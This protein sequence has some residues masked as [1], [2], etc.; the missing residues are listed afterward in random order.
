MIKAVFAITR[1]LTKS[2]GHEHYKNSL[3]TETE[4]VILVK[5][6]RIQWNTFTFNTEL[7]FK[8][9]GRSLA[10]RLQFQRNATQRIVSYRI[11]FSNES[12]SLVS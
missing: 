12:L 1:G 5:P 4:V 6:H 2:H 11:D 10:T 8:W 3:C 9:N 7:S